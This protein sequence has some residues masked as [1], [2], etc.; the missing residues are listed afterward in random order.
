MSA[1]WN[2]THRERMLPEITDNHLEAC[3]DETSETDA[4]SRIN[5][6]KFDDVDNIVE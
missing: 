4:V 5:K 6:P 1:Q 2:Q 3:G